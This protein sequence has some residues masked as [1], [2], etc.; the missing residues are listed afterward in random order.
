MQQTDNE[1]NSSYKGILKATSLFGGLQVYT[2]LVNI[3]KTKVLSVLLG[4]EGVGIEGLFKSGIE[5][6]QNVTSLGLSSSAVREVAEA[7]GTNDIKKISNTVFVVR[8]LVWATGLLGLL[9]FAVASP[10]LSKYTFGS[11]DYTISF[12][13]L[14]IVLLLDQ[15]S[16]GQKVV[17]Q[18][19]AK[20]KKLAKATALGATFGLLV[21]IPLYYLLGI[22]GIVATLILNSACSLLLS[23]YFSRTIKLQ[24]TEVSVK[25]TIADSRTMIKMGFSICL[26]TAEAALIAYLLRSYIRMESGTEGVGLFQAGFVLMNS[27]VALVFN[28]MGT[29]FYPRLANVNKDNARCKI[30][31]NEQ[32][33]VASCLLTPILVA[34]ITFVPIAIYILYT[35]EF[36]QVGVYILWASLGM[37]FRL[38]SWLVSFMFLAKGVARLFIINETAAKVYFFI[39]NII[40]YKFGGLEGLGIAFAV[41]YFLYTLQVYYLAKKKYHF[42]WDKEFLR[43]FSLMLVVVIAALLVG[44]LQLLYRYTLGTVLLIAS[45]Y[46]SYHILDKK[47]SLG[48]LIR[49]RLHK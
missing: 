22:K 42:T 19:L 11:Y 39:F 48:Q 46:M 18:G 17:L 3:I 31:I 8:R 9:V 21:S 30:I 41:S 4:P 38:S 1:V 35:D 34:F 7:N 25:Q 2:I 23:W 12:T 49:S 43:N 33:I 16:A 36:Q 10:W 27:Y 47:I 45:L 5:L 24:K 40:G 37:M 14:S 26:S 44:H 28:A 32:G 6:V 29:D 20:Y 15:I 13:F